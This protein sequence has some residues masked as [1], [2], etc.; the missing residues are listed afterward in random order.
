MRTGDLS[1][2][3]HSSS[4]PKRLLSW[5]PPNTWETGPDLLKE[6]KFKH[7]VTPQEETW[8]ASVDIRVV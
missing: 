1:E 7:T 6:T 2:E 4:T 8:Y 3:N 5:K